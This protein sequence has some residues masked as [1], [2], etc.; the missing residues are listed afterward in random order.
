MDFSFEQAIKLVYNSLSIWLENVYPKVLFRC[1]CWGLDNWQVKST[2]K[3]RQCRLCSSTIIIPV[4][5][6]VICKYGFI[7]LDNSATKTG[8]FNHQNVHLGLAISSKAITFRRV[9]EYFSDARISIFYHN[10]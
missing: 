3:Y 1:H 10:K 8:N 5:N 2:C 7:S 9:I 4:I 6:T